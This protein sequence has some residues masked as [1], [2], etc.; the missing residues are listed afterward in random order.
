MSLYCYYKENNCHF[1][2]QT[3]QYF[4]DMNASFVRV[5]VVYVCLSFIF[6]Y[7]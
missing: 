2:H 1:F 4:D 7:F 5:H 3:L 6:F